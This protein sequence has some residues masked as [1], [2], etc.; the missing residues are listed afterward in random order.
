MLQI[1]HNDFYPNRTWDVPVSGYKFYSPFMLDL[2]DQNGYRLTHLEQ[3]YSKVNTQPYSLH[4]D[5]KSIRKEWMYQEVPGADFVI[6]TGAH[7][8]HAFLF[9]RKGYSGEALDQLKYEAKTNNLLYKLIQYRGKWGV[10]FSMDYVDKLGNTME[11]LHFEYDS[12]EL[13]EILKVK[14]L[15]E[16]RVLAID[17]EDSIKYMLDKKDEWINLEFFE[18]SKYKTDFFQL[19]AERFKMAAWL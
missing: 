11:L 2:F 12:Y 9:E 1:T 16:Q 18:Q 3:S 17:W 6:T 19:P 8:N 7:I 4:A 14:E 13:D 10:D 5:E 15:V